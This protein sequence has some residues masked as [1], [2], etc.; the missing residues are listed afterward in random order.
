MDPPLFSVCFQVRNTQLANAANIAAATQRPELF[1]SFISSLWTYQLFFFFFFFGATEVDPREEVIDCIKIRP[2]TPS[3]RAA[4][5]TKEDSLR[6][7]F[8]QG[9]GRR[10]RRR[11]SGGLNKTCCCCSCRSCCRCWLPRMVSLMLAGICGSSFSECCL[12]ISLSLS[13]S[14]WL[15]LFSARCNMWEKRERDRCIIIVHRERERE[16]QTDKP[17]ERKKRFVAFLCSIFALPPLPPP[18]FPAGLPAL[19]KE[20]MQPKHSP[21]A[22]EQMPR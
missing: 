11:T 10:G 9:G 4:S 22:N 3:N 17:K 14:L 5:Q 20:P 6:T 21:K 18:F 13:L 12:W 1:L 16:R 15:F 7:F 19:K 2:P 8:N